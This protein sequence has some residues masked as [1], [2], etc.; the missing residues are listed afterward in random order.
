MI[1]LR[2]RAA[3][4]LAVPFFAL[5]AAAGGEAASCRWTAPPFARVRDG[6]RLPDLQAKPEYDPGPA[7]AVPPT[8]APYVWNPIFPIDRA[9]RVHARSDGTV[10]SIVTISGGD[11]QETHVAVL[12]YS[13]GFV[14]Q[15]GLAADYGPARASDELSG[16][17]GDFTTVMLH[18]EAEA[19]LRL[20]NVWIS[21]DA[22]SFGYRHAAGLVT[23]AGGSTQTFRPAFGVRDD[24][25]ELRSGLALQR[26]GP[27][28]ELAYLNAAT[29]AYR[30]GV[31]G[32]GVAVEVPPALDETFSAFGA[33]SYYPNLAGGGIAYRGVRYRLGSALSL[34]PLFGRP[35]YFELSIVGDD[36]TNRSRAPSSA[37][38]S[39]LMLGIGYRFGGIL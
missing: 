29:N 26:G 11:C 25:L 24:S 32:L 15:R 13:D 9:G 3:F 23:D 28:V 2:V 31:G 38:Y 17:Q 16:G 27:V 39:G 8:P 21:A 6:T 30:P 19:P 7:P 1:A 14:P 33:L 12:V 5:A 22:R 35:Y 18:A 20:R 34:A 4:M 37:S 36:R 10:S